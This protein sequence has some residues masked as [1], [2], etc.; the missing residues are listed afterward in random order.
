MRATHKN[1]MDAVIILEVFI[2]V[3]VASILRI[4]FHRF[5]YD[6]G[7]WYLN[8]SWL[9]WHGV[10]DNVSFYALG[11]PLL[12]G[13]TNSIA[14]DLPTSGLIAQSIALFFLL[15]GTYALG[16]SFFG[17]L[18]GAISVIIVGLNVQTLD[19]V[20]LLSADLLFTTAVVWIIF[21]ALLLAKEARR[22]WSVSLAVLLAIAPFIRFEGVFY[23]T[24]APLALFAIYRRKCSVRLIAQHSLIIA[25]I[26]SLFWLVYFA[27]FLSGAGEPTGTVAMRVGQNSLAWLNSVSSSLNGLDWVILI[28]GISI[29]LLRERRFRLIL[30]LLMM[31]IALNGVIMTLAAPRID[32]RYVF[33]VIPYLSI[34]YGAVIARMFRHRILAVAALIVLYAYFNSAFPA[35]V[36]LPDPLS[37]RE[38]PQMVAIQQAVEEI[39]NWKRANGY[40]NTTIY[41]MCTDLMIVAQFD[42]R[43][44]FTGLLFNSERFAP[45]ERV[46]PKIAAQ[47]ALL[48]VCPDTDIIV[49]QGLWRDL[50][51]YWH[52]PLNAPPEVADMAKL[53]LEMVGRVREYTFYRLKT[54]SNKWK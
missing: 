40:E 39:E 51:K 49:A 13:F 16:R 25:S 50:Y 28:L 2:F 8:R 35:I 33:Q 42:I 15:I 18:V 24:V 20:R 54:D 10:L 19:S 45:P 46:L 12:V 47:D 17:R 41:T 11:F 43:L 21:F 29:I 30:L 32:S 7:W 37:Y 14:K 53:P 38:H 34:L 26:T 3:V 52:D 48:L 1:F 4:E 27:W 44:P 5:Q 9:H 23:A 31:P 36:H 22:C 6:D